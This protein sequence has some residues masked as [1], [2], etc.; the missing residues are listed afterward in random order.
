MPLICFAPLKGGVGK[1]T[2]AADITDAQQ[3]SERRVL[4]LDC[5][6]QNTLRRHC[7]MALTDGW[8]FVAKLPKRPDWRKAAQRTESCVIL[9]SHRLSRTSAESM[10]RYLGPRL[11]CAVCRDEVV[12]EALAA[13]RMVLDLALDSLAAEDLREIVQGIEVALPV[14]PES[15]PAAWGAR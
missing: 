5:D 8:G 10:A 15:F 11:L 2:L 3:S 6:P 12:A 13:Q 1:T 4:T 7:G 14:V 9:L